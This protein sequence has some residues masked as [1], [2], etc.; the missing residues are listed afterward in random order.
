M[1]PELVVVFDPV[2]DML[3]GLHLLVFRG[4][5]GILLSLD[6]FLVLKTFVDADVSL[7]IGV[8]LIVSLAFY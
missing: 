4:K 6:C 8:F 1:L 2:G 7:A 5:L 3:I